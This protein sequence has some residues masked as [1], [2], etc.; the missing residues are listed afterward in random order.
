MN[1]LNFCLQAVI[2]KVDGL[3][4]KIK[5]EKPLYPRHAISDMW[6]YRGFC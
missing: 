6:I 1:K 5:S 4:E 3:T 2:P